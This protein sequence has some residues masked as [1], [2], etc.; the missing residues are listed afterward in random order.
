[1]DEGD[2]VFFYLLPEAI[3]RAI[4]NVTI[5]SFKSDKKKP[6]NTNLLLNA[7]VHSEVLKEEHQSKTW[8]NDLAEYKPTR[9]FPDYSPN[10]K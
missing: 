4:Q 10:L 3:S 2:D 5:V 8:E 6:S 1:M 7:L 9:E